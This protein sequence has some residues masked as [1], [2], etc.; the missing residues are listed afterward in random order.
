MSAVMTNANLSPISPG[1]DIMVVVLYLVVDLTSYITA[2]NAFAGLCVLTRSRSSVRVT[3]NIIA[4]AS[5]ILPQSLHY[6]V[7]RARLPLLKLW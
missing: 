4:I 2:D 6:L 7:L 1:C 3:F 5:P